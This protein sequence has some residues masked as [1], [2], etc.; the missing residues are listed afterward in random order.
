MDRD[1]D[2]FVAKHF[3]LKRTLLERLK[4][5]AGLYGKRQQTEVLIRCLH[6]GLDEIE[7]AIDEGRPSKVMGYSPK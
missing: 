1:Q 6:H 7:A 3:R 5:V 2:E 4:R